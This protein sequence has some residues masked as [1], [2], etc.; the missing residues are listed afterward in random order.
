[1]KGLDSCR[2]PFL[3]GQMP[4]LCRVYET[5]DQIRFSC[6]AENSSVGARLA[7]LLVNEGSRPCQPRL[8][9]WHAPASIK[10]EPPTFRSPVKSR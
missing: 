4:S 5:I 7:S 1:V 9:I 8:V 10:S 2:V 3:T 6:F